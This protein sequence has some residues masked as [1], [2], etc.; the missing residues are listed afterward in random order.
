MFKVKY[1]SEFLPT[2]KP[3]EVHHEVDF[4]INSVTYF[5]R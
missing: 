2:L 3:D 5:I 4:G 1:L